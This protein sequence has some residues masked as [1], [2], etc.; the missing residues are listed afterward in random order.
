M[1]LGATA[2][3]QQAGGG[4]GGEGGEGGHHPIEGAACVVGGR[5]HWRWPGQPVRRGGAREVGA[6]G[7]V[8]NEW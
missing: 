7:W 3:L 8:V 1:L 4:G 6:I 5:A 2:R